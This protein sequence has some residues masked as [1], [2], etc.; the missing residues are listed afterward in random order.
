MYS[1]D[2][3]SK[4]F[5]L[6]SSSLSSYSA[7][8]SNTFATKKKGRAKAKHRK[9]QEKYSGEPAS[10]AFAQLGLI[11][12]MKSPVIRVFR[13]PC[14][15]SGRA[16]HSSTPKRGNKVSAGLSPAEAS[17]KTSLRDAKWLCFL[18]LGEV[19]ETDVT[20]VIASGSDSACAGI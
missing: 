19:R 9:N 11:A 18:F 4:S 5:L 10:S 1:R 6:R 17:T 13:S 2:H 16:D 8:A 15:N 12:G 14:R 7:T 20:D 3:P